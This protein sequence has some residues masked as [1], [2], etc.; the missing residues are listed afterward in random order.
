MC[1][2]S[3]GAHTGRKEGWV[4]WGAGFEG[5]GGGGAITANSMNPWGA[6]ASVRHPPTFSTCVFPSSSSS[7]LPPPPSLFFLDLSLTKLEPRPTGPDPRTGL[8]Q[9][10]YEELPQRSPDTVIEGEQRKQREKVL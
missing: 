6:L 10:A 8:S 1:C 7:G 5:T 2:H 4:E 3:Q 9:L